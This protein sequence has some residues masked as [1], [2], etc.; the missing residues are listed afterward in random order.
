MPERIW[1]DPAAALEER[2]DAVV[3]DLSFEEAVAVLLGDFASLVDRGIPA[4]DYVDA[5]TGIRGVTGATAFPAGV[6]LA[7]SFDE[8]LARDYGAAVGTEARRAGFTVV[9]GPTL[10][11]ARDPS[12]GRVPEA[13]G[14]DP[15]LSG[16]IGAAHI[17]GLQGSHVVAQVKHF[18]AYTSERRRTGHGPEPARGDAFDVA[19]SPETLHDI[20]L[21][22][23]EAAVK[24]GAWSM[25]G[26]YNRLNGEYACQRPDLLGIPRRLW[27]WR[28]FYC[29]DFLYAVRDPAKALAAGLDLGALGG[30]GGRTAEMVEAGGEAWVREAVGNVVR[31][32]IGSGLVDDPLPALTTPTSPE[33]HALA[34]RA[35]IAGTVLLRNEG[36]LPL[37]P[38]GSIAVIGP[39][40]ADAFLVCGGAASVTVDPGRAVTPLAGLRARVGESAELVVAQGSLGDV[41][42]PAVPAEAFTLPDGSGP[43][44][45]VEF[46]DGERRWTE[47]L[48]RIDH[49]LDPFR[50]GERWP[51]CWRTRLTSQASGDHRLSLT[52]GGEARLFL[53]GELLLAGAREMEQFISGPRY[54]MQAVV[55]L[56]AG[57]A[58]ELTLEFEP[59]PA[60]AIPPMGV[61]PTIRLGWQPPDQ[62][63]DDAV[64]AAGSCDV[65]VVFATVASG[66]GMNRDSIGLPGDQDELIRRVAAA[67]RRTVVVLNT[68]G[69]VLMPWLT[70]VGAVLQVWYPG[71]GYGEA[72]AAVLFGDAE[73]GGRLPLTFPKRREHLPGAV[74]PGESPERLDYDAEGPFGYRSAAVL[75]HGALFPFGFGLG[76]AR[77]EAT[78]TSEPLPGGGLDL[79]ITVANPG[80]RDGVHVAQVYAQFAGEREWELVGVR[81]IPVSAGGSAG[82]RLQVGPDQLRR[83][84]DAAQA[85]VPVPGRHRIRVATHAEDP[86]VQFVLD[87]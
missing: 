43:G 44:V 76:Y 67:N 72:L 29:P 61:G 70:D 81:R 7:A 42:L 57:V 2:V 77:T 12:G 17:A 27:G 71:E 80:D 56:E 53:D 50:P 65:A 22:P 39:S 30:A 74:P 58:R 46:T 86:G 49:T 11:L 19:T 37:R 73:P 8:E 54:P 18:A 16:L 83:W 4:P 60:I 62:L 9:L 63:I 10:D 14:E 41:P 3:A 34:V 64:A 79:A 20:H 68:P 13:F 23:F 1:L 75:E 45:L 25:M 48:E 87:L 28:G 24:A 26:S 32:M 6:A 82:A 40:G 85:R 47:N 78:V 52:F 84:D 38:A 55:A 66:E 36:L 69:A 59:G 5:G 35:A 33:H 51:L 21:R 31:A 15:H